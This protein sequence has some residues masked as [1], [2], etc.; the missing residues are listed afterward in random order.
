[1]QLII[2]VLQKRAGLNL[3]NQDVFVSVAGGIKTKEP[4]MDLAVAIA[5][6]SSLK[7]K[8]VDPQICAYGEVGLSGEIR[9]VSFQN[10]RTNEATRLGFD[11][12]IKTKNLNKAISEVINV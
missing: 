8:A 10:K 4:A 11:K 9:A 5:I 1:L 12:F 7:N 2:A 6:A 3:Q